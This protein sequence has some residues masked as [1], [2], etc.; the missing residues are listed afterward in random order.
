[1]KK[2]ILTIMFFVSANI[3]LAQS[4]IT[5]T[6]TGEDGK[7]LYGVTVKVKGTLKTVITDLDGKYSIQA[8]GTD[9]LEFSFIGLE[10]QEVKVDGR[11]VVDINM[12]EDTEMLGDVV[13]T[14][15]QT[16]SKERSTGSFVSVGKEILENRPVSDLSSALL[17]VTPGMAGTIGEDG[18]VSFVIRGNGTLSSTLAGYE[19]NPLVVVD[20]FPISGDFTTINPNDIASVNILKDAAA[21]SIWGARAANGVIVVVTKKSKSKDKIRVD[22]SSFI[23]ISDKIDLDHALDIAN[24]DAQIKYNELLF[25]VNPT[26]TDPAVGG[27]FGPNKF[28]I[29]S[30]SMANVFDGKAGN[31]GRISAEEYKSRQQE[32]RNND[33][34]WID[35]YEKHLLRN[36]LLQQYNLGISGS[37]GIGSFKFTTLYEKDLTSFRE[38]NRNKLILGL[39]S[40]F[41]FTDNLSYSF[42]IN[43]HIQDDKVNG[44]NINAI[45][46]ATEP[47]TRLFDKNGNYTSMSTGDPSYS[48]FA[49]GG[50]VLPFFR[51]ELKDKLPYDLNYNILQETKKQRYKSKFVKY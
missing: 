49:P 2:V 31:G 37:S 32:L 51:D 20:G 41:K 44:T 18:K 15:Y 17:G 7:P 47:Y 3:A 19:T 45:R 27:F 43:T 30:Q 29:I 28:G 23:R 38:N 42:S 40:M 1:M 48:F 9:V 25:N 33:G 10:K 21:T 11:E 14:G 35:D 5:G 4:P 46:N 12:G 36:Q 34:K 13:V 39:E 24:T 22:F 8:L 16:I 50:I 26:L 6:V